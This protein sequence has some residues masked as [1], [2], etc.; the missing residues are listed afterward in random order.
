MNTRIQHCLRDSA[1]WVI[2]S[3]NPGKRKEVIS[4]LN[5]ESAEAISSL[6]LEFCAILLLNLLPE[7]AHFQGG[8]YVEL[9]LD[10]ILDSI[11]D[12]F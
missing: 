11:L 4:S 8:D 7:L 2:S 5:L 1:V 12:P 3:L 9:L 10:S 6:N